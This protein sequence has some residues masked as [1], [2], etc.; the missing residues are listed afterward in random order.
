MG[1]HRA[2]PPEAIKEHETTSTRVRFINA[3][4]L[5]GFVPQ[6]LKPAFF[7]ALN[8]TAKQAAEKVAFH[9]AAAISG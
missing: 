4:Q 9:A 5:G 8:G 1:C 2:S 6:G 7:Q 3:F